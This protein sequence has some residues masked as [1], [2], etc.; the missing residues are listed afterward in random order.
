[1]NVHSGETQTNRNRITTIAIIEP[2]K[3]IACDSAKWTRS[4]RRFRSTKSQSHSEMRHV[5][6]RTSVIQLSSV[7]KTAIRRA[8]ETR[9]KMLCVWKLL[10]TKMHCRQMQ[11]RSMVCNHKY[12]GLLCGKANAPT[13][14]TTTS[15]GG[16]YWQLPAHTGVT[17]LVIVRDHQSNP[18]VLRTL[19]SP[20]ANGKKIQERSTAE[21]QLHQLHAWV[22]LFRTY[23]L[24]V[25]WRGT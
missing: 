14:A 3:R 24:G 7:P 4:S 19:Y 18:V 17:L 6:S 21:N 23:G 22:C 8:L 9:P 15:G 16:Q 12:N 20:N 10:A 13:V 1:M 25:C 2:P 5:W 11:T